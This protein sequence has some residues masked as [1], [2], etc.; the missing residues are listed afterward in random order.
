M[1]FLKQIA[2]VQRQCPDILQR[3]LLSDAH[4]E[5]VGRLFILDANPTTDNMKALVGCWTRASILMARIGD[6]HGGPGKTVES[7]AA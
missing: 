7:R 2:E 3:K 4:E 5:V 1:N 6:Y